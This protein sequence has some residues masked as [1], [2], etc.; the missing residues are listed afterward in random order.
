MPS[1]SQANEH[2]IISFEQWVWNFSSQD[3]EEEMAD[4]KISE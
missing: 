1:T 4:V 3:Q 2:Q